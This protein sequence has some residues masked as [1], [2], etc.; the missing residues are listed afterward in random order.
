MRR[1]DER[2]GCKQDS[3]DCG[4]QRAAAAH[5]S[6]Q[7]RRKSKPAEHLSKPE[8]RCGE[9]RA[10]ERVEPDAMR[11]GREP[12][13]ESGLDSHGAHG[14][15]DERKQNAARTWRRSPRLAAAYRGFVAL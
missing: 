8:E 9:R 14:Q 15:N 12:S 13:T 3:E 11:V 2:D 10:C 6:Q 4:A 1:C 7:A 5:F